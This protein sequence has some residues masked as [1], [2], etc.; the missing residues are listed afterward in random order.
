MTNSRSTTRSF[1]LILVGLVVGVTGALSIPLAHSVSGGVSGTVGTLAGSQ[2][3]VLANLNGLPRL[4]I[5]EGTLTT[6][7]IIAAL[8]ALAAALAGAVLGGL[9]GMRYHRKVDRAGFDH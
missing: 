1:M 2:F 3:D 5:N 6:G 7:G 4:P 8:L 9:A